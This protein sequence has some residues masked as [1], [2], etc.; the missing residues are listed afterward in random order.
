[1]NLVL[2]H[3]FGGSP[4][5]WNPLFDVFKKRGI[6]NLSFTPLA[7]NSFAPQTYSVPN[8]AQ[9]IHT[10]V[11]KNVQEP[12]ILVGHSM[13]GKLALVMASLG[14]EKLRGVV[15]LAPSPPTPE[16]FNEEIRQDMLATHA[17]RQGAEKTVRGVSYQ[18]LPPAVMEQAIEDNINTSKIMWDTW[19]EDGTKEDIS[20]VLP[21]IHLPVLVIAGAHDANMTPDL[22]RREIV[23]KIPGA[24]LEVVD[25]GHLIPMEL[26]EVTATVLTNFVSELQRPSSSAPS[27]GGFRR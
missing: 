25:S 16:P 20:D 22:L 4:D 10:F 27:R 2:L 11:E 24:K 23:D 1:M 18:P 7:L 9:D 13:G 19:L 5:S 8:M 14:S 15:L 6:G 26:P 21:Q 3:Y 12:Y 17:S